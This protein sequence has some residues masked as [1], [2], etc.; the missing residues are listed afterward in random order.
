MM[1]AKG[2]SEEQHVQD[3]KASHKK[4]FQNISEEKIKA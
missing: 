2:E 3:P 4:S 1:Q